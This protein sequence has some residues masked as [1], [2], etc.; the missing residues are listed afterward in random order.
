MWNYI[1]N[2][3]SL[4]TGLLVQE[5]KVSKR[6]STDREN[7]IQFLNIFRS[8]SQGNVSYFLSPPRTGQEK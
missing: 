8:L 7:F 1:S 2:I 5:M 6:M 4:E 3:C